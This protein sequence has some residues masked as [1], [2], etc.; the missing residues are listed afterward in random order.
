VLT[1]VRVA[2]HGFVRF[3][4]NFAAYRLSDFALQFPVLQ[5]GASSVPACYGINA[6]VLMATEA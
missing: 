4:A 6:A 1:E 5:A 2:G 3:P